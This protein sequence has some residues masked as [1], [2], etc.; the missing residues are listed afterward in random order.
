MQ[1]L[2]PVERR[3]WAAY[4]RGELI[5][6]R[7]DGAAPEVRA[8]VLAALL[9]GGGPEVVPGRVPALRF[10]GAR[11][12]GALDL[13]YAHVSA[14]ILMHDCVF[15]RPPALLEA[16]TRAVDLTGCAL[17]GL[18]ARGLRS[19][20]GVV[21]SGCRITGELTLRGARIG[22]SLHIRQARLSNPGDR[23]MVADNAVIDG[24]LAMHEAEVRGQLRIQNARV[25]GRMLMTAARLVNTDGHAIF[26]GGLTVEGGAFLVQGFSADGEIRLIGARFR[27]NLTMRNVRLRAPGGCAL[28]LDHAVIGSVL[29]G[30]EGFT[31][32]GEVRLI[33]AQVAGP[34]NLNGARLNGSEPSPAAPEGA[35]GSGPD[36]TAPDGG[37]LALTADSLTVGGNMEM[38]HGFHATGAIRM[39]T[40]RINGRL[41]MH[42]ARVENPDGVALRLSRAEIGSDFFCS[43][44][45]VDGEL[46]LAGTRIGGR[47]DM[48]DVAVHN[49]GA[50][51]LIAPFLDVSELDLM[52]RSVRGKV[53]LRHARVG[54]LRD[55]AVVRGAAVELD[56]L[57]YE[58]L[59]PR[60]RARERLSWLG[61]DARG[62]QPHPYEQLAALYE[63]LGDQT[64]A[65]RVL[66]QRERLRRRTLTS[67][68]RVWG[69]LQ[70]GTVAYGYQPWR[71]A[72]WLVLLVTAG[73]VAYGMNEP[74]P[75]KLDEAPRFNPVGYTLDLLLPFVD[76]GQERAFDPVDG[77]QWLS[78]GL[79]AAGWVLV[80][81]IAAGAARVLTRR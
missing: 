24:D 49:P 9:L 20:G 35:G 11:V 18:E 50:A 65:R 29:D 42:R 57:T 72:L 81:T 21:L 25:G 46:R 77:W 66:L 58:A 47:A 15:E 52:P 45:T 75:L 23:A 68:G 48:R 70:D 13:S 28:N 5:D 19:D 8:E 12:T 76:L 79:V 37:G 62:Y 44:M 40:A 10:A 80:T 74:R 53:V 78:Y 63:R 2:S 17:P 6:F 43:E 27:A 16:T 33:G 39:P 54:V 32:E 7:G 22:G 31:A 67:L 34:L 61:R 73:S 3:L 30:G 26:G 51:A 71:A 55:N 36:S 69:L 60:L 38:Q 64:D 56:G 4:P 14:P 1:D 41:E 59:E